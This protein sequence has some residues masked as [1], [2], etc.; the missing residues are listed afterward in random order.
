MLDIMA[1]KARVDATPGDDVVF[2][3]AQVAQILAQIALGNAARMTLTNIGSIARMSE[4]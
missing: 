4:R 2:S 3:K 1:I